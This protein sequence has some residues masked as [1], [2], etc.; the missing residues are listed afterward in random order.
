MT[1]TSPRPRDRAFSST[2]HTGRS[3]AGATAICLV[4]AGL[5]WLL[6]PVLVDASLVLVF[7]LAVVLSGAMF[8]RGPAT[9]AAGL[10]V[11][12][13]NLS[14]VPPRLSLSVAD[15]RFYFTFAVM[16]IV[17]LVVGHL[18]AG[19]KAQANAAR[20]S[21]AQVLSLYGI[22]RDLGRALTAEQ[23]AEITAAF[24]RQQ[25]DSDS[26]LWL[27][28][29]HGRLQGLVGEP[30]EA[31]TAHAE[32]VAA[33][34][35]EG[36]T[37]DGGPGTRSA[38][39]VAL[40]GTMAVRGALAVLAGDRAAGTAESRQL[41]DTCSALV[42]S[43]LERVHY[44]EVARESAVQIEG[45]RLRNALLSAISHDLRTP[46]ASMVGLAETLQLTRPAPS[47][48]QAD[49]ASAMATTARRMSSLVNNLLDMARL[50]AGAV[51]LDLQ[52]QP[53]E[54]VV[55]SALA[56]SA[57]VLS[58]HR[59]DVRIAPDMP[60]VCIDAVLLERLL[61]NL[62]ENAARYTPAGCH[63]CIAAHGGGGCF[64][65]VVSDDGPGLPAGR[66]AHM[67]HKFERGQREGNTPGVGL[68]L[69]LCSAIVQAHGGQIVAGRAPEGGACF[70]V[71]LPQGV[72]PV[73]PAAV[74]AAEAAGP[75]GP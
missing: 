19:L 22:A 65:L 40:R 64:E 68:G 20:R 71:R 2:P 15:E 67:F 27:R 52:W 9:W 42:G 10:S 26:V 53:I 50:D 56:A 51:R 1:T 38:A 11:L 69:A 28:D 41:L 44:I 47:P 73:L 54:E 37:P 62:L 39:F 74:E 5:A 33:A 45:E 75:G 35:G 12:L 29:R 59:V 58:Q 32:R 34:A 43:A 60:L 18:T 24:V 61:V 14:F 63:I 72:P 48:Q 70:T 31:S 30:D 36:A 25:F 16:L 49:I 3:F 66:E 8:G 13:F 4:A 46:L 23:V 57:P 6:A 55:G 21:E 17:G 7:L